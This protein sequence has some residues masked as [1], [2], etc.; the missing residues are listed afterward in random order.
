MNLILQL[1][2][3]NAAFKSWDD[4]DI[5]AHADPECACE[6]ARILR[7]KADEVEAH[8]IGGSKVGLRD[9]NGNVVGQLLLTENWMEENDND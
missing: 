8:S 2:L 5:G 3:E 7:E 6:V 4:A 9:R 1:N